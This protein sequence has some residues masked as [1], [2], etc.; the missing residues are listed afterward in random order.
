MENKMYGELSGE[1]LFEVE[2]GVAPLVITLLKISGG[3]FL[4]GAG[5]RLG[6]EVYEGVKGLFN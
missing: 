5:W 6:E 4:A 2:G 3:A 1:E